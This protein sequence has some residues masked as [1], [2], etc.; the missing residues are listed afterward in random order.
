MVLFNL[1]TVPNPVKKSLGLGTA[2][3]SWAKSAARINGYNSL[4][5]LNYPT[6]LRLTS[7]AN[8]SMTDRTSSTLLNFLRSVL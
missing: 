7:M 1:S 5:Q 6:I 8:F 4:N 3:V 2:R